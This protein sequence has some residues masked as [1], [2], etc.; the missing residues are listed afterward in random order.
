MTLYL[1]TPTVVEHYGRHRLFSRVGLPVGT[2]ILKEDGFYV[3]V[4]DPSPERIEAADEVYL[5]GYV[6]EI[7]AETAAALTLAG[8]GA[9][10]REEL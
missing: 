5:G 2:S 1:E 3:N 9:N 7:S 8:Y 6:H 10:I 4:R